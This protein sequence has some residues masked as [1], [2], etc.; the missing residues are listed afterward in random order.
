MR[1]RGTITART[2]GKKAF[3]KAVSHPEKVASEHETHKWKT[4]G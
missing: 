4:V 3:I 2:G 1:F